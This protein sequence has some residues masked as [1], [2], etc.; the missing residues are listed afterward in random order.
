M[1]DNKTHPWDD[2]AHEPAIDEGGLRAPAH[3]SFWG[4]AWWWFDFLI[5][6]NIARF[7]FIALL[8]VIGLILLK[9]DLITAYYDRWTRPA[10]HDHA[11]SSDFE[12]YCPMHP[13]VIRD[14]P[15][16]KCPICFMPLSKRKKGEHTEEALPPGVVNR[17]Q[18]TPYRVVLAG[19][20]TWNVEYLPLTKEITT[21][22]FV[23]FNERE[24]KNVA[25]RVKGRLD[26]LFVN[27]TGQMVH[28]DDKLASLYSPDL[29]VTVENLL[30][31]RKS[32]SAELQKS[33][34]KRL[35]LWGISKDQIDEILKTGKANSLLII[36]S[37]IEG[38]V[39]K[40]YVK[41]GQ[42][43]D[44]GSPLYDI[45][46]LSTV[47][48]QAQVYEEDM[49]F[50]PNYHNP[51]KKKE[52]MKVGLPV[53]ATT[54]ALP[55]RTFEG[56]L[57]FIFPH[58]DQDSRT[59][60]VRFELDNPDHVL[61]PGATATV[62]LRIPPKQVDAF[63]KAAS[64]DWLWETATDTSLRTAI[65]PLAVGQGAGFGPL[66]KAAGRQVLLD[67]G[68]VMA[69]PESAV[70][71]TGNLRIVYR[72]VMPGEYEGV[73]VELGPRMLGPKDVIY[74]PVLRGLDLG[75]KIVV[76][77]SFLIDAETRLNPAAGSIYFGGSSGGKTGGSTVR[78][79]TPEDEEAKIKATLAKLPAEDRS[80][81]EAQNFCPVLKDS[82]LGSMGVPDKIM[83]EG[84]PVFLCC[85]SCI[86]GA[87]A[88]PKDTLAKVS[89]LKKA[90]SPSSK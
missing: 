28:E 4:K 61:R 87:Q 29:V 19:V 10:A 79:S 36:R 54:R 66:V 43:V 5:L 7:R 90:N 89:Q 6:V 34:E 40:K 21:V 13:T 1:S 18:L 62:K 81:A 27:E 41:E 75:D 37:P 71:D 39:L 2:S 12:F 47:W 15:K 23:D 78:P 38:H 31:A 35:E 58:V 53:S 70:I 73:K 11:G 44:E 30:Q 45:V 74:Y 85:R 32:G 8:V 82:R 51:L 48:I 68:L 60:M 63:S 25:A 80:L 64:Q 50:L 16:E 22:G 77:G 46:D 20:Q 86:K 24:M 67:K 49:A 76:V 9:W 14:N 72:E 17:V 55:G 56:R 83:I 84:Q 26:K 42:Y 59:V 3:L 33:A 57:T 65:S 69:V 88:N 52:A